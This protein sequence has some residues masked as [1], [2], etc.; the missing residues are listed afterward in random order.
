MRTRLTE[1]TSTLSVEDKSR[2]RK[3]S[4]SE[5]EKILDAM[6]RNPT[7]E[8]QGRWRKE[9]RSVLAARLDG[10]FIKQ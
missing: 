7:W 4:V 1:R 8:D 5:D 6:N 3:Q 2:G 10:R 9:S